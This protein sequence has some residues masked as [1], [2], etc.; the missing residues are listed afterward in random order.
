MGKLGNKE[1]SLK[2]ANIKSE[3]SKPVPNHLPGPE[4]GARAKIEE[5]PLLRRTEIRENSVLS[6]RNRQDTKTL[7]NPGDLERKLNKDS[8]IIENSIEKTN[9]ENDQKSTADETFNLMDWIKRNKYPLPNEA[10]STP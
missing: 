10:Y 7:G 5:F 3:A 6:N 8:T 2:K 4:T 9:K 1:R